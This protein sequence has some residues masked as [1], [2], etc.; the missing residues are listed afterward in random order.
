MAIHLAVAV[1]TIL[2]LARLLHLASDTVVKEAVQA[3]QVVGTAAS[4]RIRRQDLPRQVV[5][6][7]R[8]KSPLLLRPIKG[9]QQNKLPFVDEIHGGLVRFRRQFS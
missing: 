4:P 7:T 3:V 1:L 5:P 2:R 8:R 9:L 6:T